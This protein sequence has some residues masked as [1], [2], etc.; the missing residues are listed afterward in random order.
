MCPRPKG[1]DRF[2]TEI[3]V[4]EPELLLFFAGKVVEK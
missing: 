1:N 4:T 3:C 2:E